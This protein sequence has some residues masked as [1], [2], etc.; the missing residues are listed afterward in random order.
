MSVFA[1]DEKCSAQYQ[2]TLKDAAEVVIPLASI[3][4]ATLTLRDVDTNT[5]LNERNAQNIRNAN[6]VTIHATSGLLTWALQPGDSVIVTSS[7]EFEMHRAVIEIVYSGTQQVN[8]EFY[9]MVRNLG[10]VP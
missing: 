1:L 3:N 8:H 5:I 2:A 6:N 9:L 4:T 7:K 10:D